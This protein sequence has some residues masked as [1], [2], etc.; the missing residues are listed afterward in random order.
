MVVQCVDNTNGTTVDG[1]YICPEQCQGD[2]AWNYSTKQCEAAPRN[3]KSLGECDGE[4]C[5]LGNPISAGTG[6]KYQTETDIRLISLTFSRTY[7]STELELNGAP[8]STV[9]GAHWNHSFERYVVVDA[10]DAN[11]AYIT[12]PDGKIHVFVFSGGQ[13]LADA[14]VFDQLAQ[15]TDPQ[16]TPTGWRY[17]TTDNATEDYDTA[18]KLVSITDVRGNV[19]TLSYDG[20]SRLDRVNTTPGES[21]QFGYDT[22]N[23]IS[24]VTDHAGRVWGYR[25]DANNNLEYVD[26]PDT[27]T[28]QYHYEDSRF[29]NALTGITDE[30]AMPG[31]RYASFGYDSYGRAI[32]ST[33]AGDAQKVTISYRD[34]TG[35]RT[36][37]NSLSQPS[38]YSTAVQLGVALVTGVS[39]PGCS[40][41]D[42]GNSGFV[43]DAANNLIGRNDSAGATRFGNYD[44]RGQFGCKVEGVSLSDATLN[45]GDCAFDPVA[46]PDARRTDYTYHA[47]LFNKITTIIEPS[48]FPGNSKTTTYSYDA[49][50]NRISAV[51][52]GY[53]RA[54]TAII[55]TTSWQY[56][57][58]GSL[59]CNA[60]PLHQLCRVDGPRVD[61]TDI[62]V[63]RYYPN[64]SSL[65]VGTRSRLLE[66]ED[67]NGVLIRSAIQYTAT[68]KV[69]SESRPNDLTLDYTYYPGNDRLQTLI[70]SGNGSTRVTQWTYLA[71]G[72]VE[73][74]T[75][76]FGTADATTL[77]FGYDNARRLTR[78]TDGLGN[79]IEYTLDTEGNHTFEKTY[80]NTDAL[81][82]Q[83]SQTFDIY[84]R[85]D[86]T[87]QANETTNPNFAP[88][89]TLGTQTDGKGTVTDYG[90]DTLKRLTHVIQDQGGADPNTADAKTDYDYDVADRLTLVTDPVNGNTTYDYD[91]LGNLLTQSSPD[92]GTTSFTY[93][94]AGNLE[95][96]LDA[97]GQSFSYSYDALNRL[98]G[99]D[100]PGTDDDIT[101]TYDNCTN[102]SGRLCSVA[103]S[104][105]QW[106]AGN[107]VRYRYNVFGDITQQQGLLYGY[108]AQG[109]VQ[110]LDY[111]SGS[112]LTTLYDAA[113]QASQVDFT[114]NGQTQTLASNLSYAPFGPITQLT[115]G[116]GLLLTQALDD[117]Y[118]LTAQTV[119]GVLERSY[120]SYDGNG[121]RLSQTDTLATNSV[122]TYDP[123]NRLDRSSGPFGSRDYTYDKNGNRTLIDVD[124]GTSVTPYAY[125]PNSNRLESL[126]A[127]DVLLDNNGNT[128]KQ[129][130][131]TYSYTHHNRL[132]TATENATLKASFGYNG[133]GQ[134]FR[135]TDDT[136][137]DGH[138]Y[139]Y[140]LNGELQAETDQDGNVLTEY[141][142]LN[143][144]LLAIYAPDDD[145]DGIP[146][147]EEAEQGTL[148]VNT[149]S[150]GDGL[151]NLSEWFHHGT[152]SANTD[153]DSDGTLDGVEIAGNTDPN[154]TTDFPGNGDIN[155]D[156]VTN[157]GDLV[158]LYQFVTGNRTPTTEEFTHADM[159]QDG[160]LTV[161]DILLL[162]RQL[163]TAALGINTTVA[164][165][166]PLPSL[167]GQTWPAASSVPF[168]ADWFNSLISQAHA[169][170]A[171]S[172]VLYYVHNDPLGTPQALTDESGIVVWTGQYDPFGKTTIN[173]D[174]DGDETPVTFNV[175][176]PGQYYDRETGLHYNY[177]RY[178][179]PATGR[180]LTSDPIG[181]Y[182]GP[183]TYAY[184][185]G[186]PLKWTDRRGLDA[187]GCDG[188]PNFLESNCMLNMCA[189]HDLCY[190]ENRCRATSWL[191]PL[192][193]CNLKCN[194][195]AVGDA[196]SSGTAALL[197]IECE[198]KPDETPREGSCKQK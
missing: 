123:L 170:P 33:H 2:D 161:A 134:R 30:R 168:L 86:T 133:L 128:L 197:G 83:L 135:K 40:T 181:L 34:A 126:G 121:N 10:L 99:L 94:A 36:V 53:T 193:E 97:N 155:T 90:Y 180:Y 172:G 48:V 49:F 149:D 141:L 192:S 61:E 179:D 84:N 178:Y 98:T 5:C 28:K 72:E 151:T 26:N 127:T 79:Y 78:I 185:G 7:N 111:P 124:T 160:E 82:K 186:N 88:D 93:D 163:L 25:Y 87:G 54:G 125:E 144:Q 169:V 67:A 45:I 32:L 198:L 129:A 171:N 102:G 95:T 195:P 142:Y 184:V 100:A 4:S 62:T 22:S 188:I 42:A 37:T 65:P 60:V 110:T 13:W 17:T 85:L 51:I 113:G 80:D 9:M 16:G 106:P 19:Q 68:G 47:T 120:P 105:D 52:D 153:S 112:R 117:A 41:C 76:G 24:T 176:L 12:R 166:N 59:E 70:E 18:G 71:T 191:L 158:L 143:G 11:K 118:R 189:E 104:T 174:P 107:T 164:K 183:N 6:N 27:T 55:R 15:L 1:V 157:L 147:T 69:L 150:D 101:Y 196:I 137:N 173:E 165:A 177:F 29:P 20:N 64:D 89:G 38:T 92:T 35:E 187:P 31:E 145:Q 14:D 96:R 73:T 156:N 21:L 154:S 23:R 114:V 146:N 162:Q 159:N 44:S 130:A 58:D 46:S 74:I 63:Y 140:G 66:V 8:V 167:R 175:R 132:A 182:G 57:G 148:P 75:T 39:G 152:D 56:G 116:N 194:L 81:K 122:H 91:D 108:D 43:Y 77:T 3:E 109:R 138:H 119:P 103:Y 139:L 50:G 136:T 115:F 131:W 190:F